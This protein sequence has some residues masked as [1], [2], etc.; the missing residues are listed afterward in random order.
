[1]LFS[2]IRPQNFQELVIFLALNRPGTRKKSDEI[3]RKKAGK[4][5]KTFPTAAISKIMD[6][7]LGFIIFEE[8]ISKIIAFVYDCSLSHAETIRRELTTKPL[9]ED[10][11]KA[12]QA[13]GLAPAEI[14]SLVSEINSV[15]GYTFNKSHAVAYAYLTY[16]LSYLKANY[17]PFIITN[18]LNKKKEKIL[19]Y[20]QESFFYGLE[21][22]KPSLNNSFNE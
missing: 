9:D 10:F 14:N 2:K 1:M 16:Y 4:I 22:K 11:V 17:F 13:K 18:L 20:L 6:E 21:I 8:Q 12:A 5:N 3:Q 7:G 19:P 15:T